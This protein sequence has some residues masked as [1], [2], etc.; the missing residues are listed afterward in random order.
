MIQIFDES[1]LLRTNSQVQTL[2]YC[3][4]ESSSSSEVQSLIEM[5]IEKSKTINS[6]V[7]NKPESYQQ[8]KT[9]AVETIST[10]NTFAERLKLVLRE[11][12]ITQ[13]ELAKCMGVS[14]S[15]ISSL[16]TGKRHGIEYSTA[17]SNA[18]GINK[19]WLAYGEGEMT[20]FCTS[21]T[22]EL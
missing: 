2:L 11:S 9:P 14:Q 12:G 17:I 1:K 10:K 15:L 5:A 7:E 13:T 20:D 4:L 16:V 8:P 6:I 3:A 21:K 18:L 19:W 22:E